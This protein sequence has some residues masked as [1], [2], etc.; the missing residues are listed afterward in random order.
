[1]ATTDVAWEREEV[2]RAV[3]VVVA[4]ASS[5]IPP[6]LGEESTAAGGGCD[7]VHE[8]RWGRDE[9]E[10]VRAGWRWERR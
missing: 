8:A 5:A 4:M 3:V 6:L 10:M 9:D 1:M 7:R 2:R